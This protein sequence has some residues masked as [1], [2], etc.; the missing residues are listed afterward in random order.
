M[1]VDQSDL[2]DGEVSSNLM[3]MSLNVP[4]D[5]PEKLREL[6][7]GKPKMGLWLTD[8]I[9]QMYD[10]RITVDVKR[11]D[12]EGLRLLVMGLAGQ[13]QSLQGEMARTQAQL[14]ALIAQGQEKK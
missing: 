13:V 10:N 3:R 11:M 12:V 2:Q 4:L 5:V 1:T 9:R 6:A 8:L 7:G 14:A